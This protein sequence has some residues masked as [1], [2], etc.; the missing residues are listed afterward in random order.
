MPSLSCLPRPRRAAR[1]ATQTT[2]CIPAI[3]GLERARQSACTNYLRQQMPPGQSLPYGDETVHP[4]ANLPL[5]IQYME[6]GHGR[7]GI[8]AVRGGGLGLPCQVMPDHRTSSIE[9]LIVRDFAPADGAAAII[10]NLWTLAHDAV[11]PYRNWHE[12]YSGSQAGWMP[13]NT[14]RPWEP[15][16]EPLRHRFCGSPCA[17]GFQDKRT[18]D[19]CHARQMRYHRHVR[20]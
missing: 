16:R 13:W 20:P 18:Q 12:C 19:D 8:D 15:A 17:I 5:A 1:T 7:G 3:G 6:D 4:G 14:G 9:T 10:E 11:I 2:R